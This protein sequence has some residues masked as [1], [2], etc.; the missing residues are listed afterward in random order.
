MG[1]NFINNRPFTTGCDAPWVLVIY[2]YTR[3]FYIR[4]LLLTNG[5]LVNR[6]WRLPCSTNLAN[7]RHRLPQDNGLPN[8]R[9]GTLQ[10]LRV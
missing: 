7:I 8:K 5:H 2:T 9:K 6:C 3:S 10:A 1:W 4:M